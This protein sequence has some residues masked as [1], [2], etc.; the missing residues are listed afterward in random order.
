MTRSNVAVKI[1]I[2][3]IGFA[4]LVLALFV[5]SC[6]KAQKPLPID[7]QIIGGVY[8][9]S[10]FGFA[11]SLPNGWSISNYKF[12][13][14]MREKMEDRLYKKTGSTSAAE[15]FAKETRLV[16]A[17]ERISPDTGMR[18]LVAFY[19]MP[20]SW[21]SS[22]M[23]ATE[24]VAA[25]DRGLVNGN[26]PCERIGQIS[27]VVIGGRV[28]SHAAYNKPAHGIVFRQDYLVT[29]LRGQSLQIIL[30]AQTESDLQDQTA[31]L[32]QSLKF[33]ES[34]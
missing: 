26:P 5:S 22:S 25:L 15:L 2:T 28:F 10:Y 19:T 20:C 29:V 6:T 23:T 18:E 34:Q 12:T 1:V 31:L 13:A 9:N 4:S 27:D 30:T 7:G 21:K 16:L 17:L 3:R 11:M 8:T 33:S 24:I 32:K 14:E